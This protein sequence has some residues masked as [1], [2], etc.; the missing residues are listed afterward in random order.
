MQKEGMGFF[1]FLPKSSRIGGPKVAGSARMAL[2]K[3]DHDHGRHGVGRWCKVPA[4]QGARRCG[5]AV[6]SFGAATSV[7]RPWRTQPGAPRWFVGARPIL[8]VRKKK[9]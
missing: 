6:G 5:M 9:N 4:A 7:G 1:L 3:C 8:V 2:A